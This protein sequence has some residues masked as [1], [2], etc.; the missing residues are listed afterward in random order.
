[1]KNQ[2]GGD[3]TGQKIRIV[4]DYAKA[5]LQIMK[6]HPY[7]KTIYFDGFAGTG[8]I[9]KEGTEDEI[10]EGASSKILSINEPC[11]FDIYYFVELD[12][13]KAKTLELKI[14]NDFPT[15]NAYVVS[16]D[17]NEKLVAMANFLKEKSKKKEIYKVLCFIDPF[18]MQINWKSLEEL[19]GLGIDLWILVPTGV[20]ANRLLKKNGDISEAWLKKLEIF[21]GIPQKVVYDKFYRT[22]TSFNLFGEETSII[23]KEN[24]AIEKIHSLYTEKLLTVFKFVSKPFRLRNSKNSTMYHFLMATNNI[25]ALKIANDIIRPKYK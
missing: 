24:N 16:K 13:A 12:V 20:G 21:L 25:N 19:T 14:K 9:I 15:K 18:G 10:I 4:Y 1:M 17:C 2:F 3:W 11:S 22:S 7:W 23:N 6:G 5:Y 8:E